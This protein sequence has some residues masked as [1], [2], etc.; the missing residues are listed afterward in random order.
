M[1]V[2]CISIQRWM[3]VRLQGQSCLCCLL[4]C[5]INFFILFQFRR[6]QSELA[7]EFG[8][9]INVVSLRRYLINLLEPISACTFLYHRLGTLH[10]GL[11]VILR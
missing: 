7:D 1:I 6:F 4:V 5:V 10:Q 11:V 3:R 8:D 2:C 9:D